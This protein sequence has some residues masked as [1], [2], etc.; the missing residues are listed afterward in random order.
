MTNAYPIPCVRAFIKNENGQILL[1]KRSASDSFAGLWC[2]P[3]GKVDVG[4]TVTQTVNK[5]IWEETGLYCTETNFLFFLDSLPSAGIDQHYIVF[6]Y[7][8]KTEGII[9]LNCESEKF[10]W[11]SRNNMTNYPIAFGNENGIER[12]FLNYHKLSQ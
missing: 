7:E 10:E 5:E 12:Y 3:G 4:L 11:V 1:L 6:Y 9:T 2:L 8:C